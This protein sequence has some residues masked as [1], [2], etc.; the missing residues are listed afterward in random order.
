MTETDENKGPM[1]KWLE[2]LGPG[3]RQTYESKF[4][5]FL[6]W[7][8][9]TDREIVVEW[10]A[11]EDRDEF[12]KDWGKVVLRYYQH[13]LEQGA[14][15][16]TARTHV[17]AARSFF[18]SQ[19][20]KLKIKK[21]AIA[22]PRAARG[23]HV[24]SRG[25]LQKMYKFAG[26]REKA[27]LSTAVSLGWSASDFLSL[28]KSFLERYI[29][30]AR[31]EGLE[32]IRFDWEREKT[33]EPILGILTPEAIGSLEEWFERIPG[34]RWAFPREAGNGERSISQDSLN[35][36]L[37]A[38]VKEA[39]ISTT[40]SVRF[41]LLRKF[42]MSELA[43]A[44]LNEWEV[45]IILGKAIPISDSTYLQKI[46]NDAFEKYVQ[47]GYGRIRLTGFTQKNHDRLG[48][49]DE[50]VKLF[51]K[52]LVPLLLGAL[53]EQG[54]DLEVLKRDAEIE[55]DRGLIELATGE[56]KKVLKL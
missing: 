1:E 14:K 22:K 52:A 34:A 3:S 24:F 44:G 13:L 12:R 46:K 31:S 30:R 9:K 29:K 54:I 55:D 16:N 53:K 36:I 11:V 19:C 8:D 47:L 49:L 20:D 45:K 28:E 10:K 33:G 35:D 23:E 4:K 5:D 7:A 6:N 32:F 26:V 27:I 38:L 48:E 17:I 56:L 42:L 39:N 2:E 25:D 37:R 18:A 51:T 41:H 15:I 43:S 40:G 21:G 50:T